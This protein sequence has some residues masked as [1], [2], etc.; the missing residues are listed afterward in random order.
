MKEASHLEFIWFWCQ[1]NSVGCSSLSP[2]FCMTYL[3]GVFSF[4]NK[5]INIHD[6]EELFLALFQMYYELPYFNIW[7]SILWR[8][9]IIFECHSLGFASNHIVFSIRNQEVASWKLFPQ[10]CLRGMCSPHP[11]Y[12]DTTPSLSQVKL[13]SLRLSFFFLLLEWVFLIIDAMDLHITLDY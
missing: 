1:G 7:N 4:D 8:Y 10:A 5:V 2:Q 9:C 6:N 11:P 3:C 12:V 13:P